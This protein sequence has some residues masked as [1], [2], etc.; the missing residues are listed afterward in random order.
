MPQI[1]DYQ[2]NYTINVTATEGVRQV[3]QFAAAVKELNS[4]KTT[5]STAI[6][7][8]N[9]MMQQIEKTFRPNGR[10]RDYTFKLDIET[11][12]TEEKLQRVKTL[13]TE[14]K[15]LTTSI[16][17]TVNAGQKL[18]TN[19][20]RSQTRALVNKKELEGQKEAAKK[21]ASD[22]MKSVGEVQKSITKVIGKINA[23][24][25]SLEKG[26][27]INIK[28]DVA[29][30]RLQ[31]ILSLL[32]QIKGASKMSLGIQMNS[33]G[34]T[35][36]AASAPSPAN[37]QPVP[38]IL[39]NNVWGQQ[40][41]RFNK[42]REARILK[43]SQA[44]Q[45]HEYRQNIQNKRNAFK[46]F[47]QEER[48]RQKIYDDYEKVKVENILR[49]ERKTEKQNKQNAAVAVRGIRQQV[50]TVKTADNSRR[51]AAINRLQYSRR[52]SLRNLPIVGVMN[53]YMAYS[54]I[55][56]ELS[57]AVNYSNIM[58]SAHSI[59]R[60]ADSDLSTFEARFDRMSRHIRKI[61]VDTK[62]TA[63]E[64][65]GAAKF[66]AMAGMDIATIN[67]SM[68]PIANLAL[69]GDNDVSLIA[70]LTTNIMSGYNIQSESMGS[71]ADIITSTISRANV[72]VWKK[73]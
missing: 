46:R 38:F 59:L 1:Q 55:K 7:N 71:V 11:K 12:G 28:T 23:A 67:A 65:A 66:L 60:V 6:T 30:R 64:I 72:N 70:D 19:A 34:K 3:Q 31:E 54:F 42:V 39:S 5:F 22:S 4:A 13:I 40:Q 18:D 9:G 56:S 43:E 68:R 17:L 25:L 2:V 51:R 36:P 69:I 62:F 35:F 49:R 32:H 41:A 15:E 44:E 63:V 52:P 57:S 48:R 45:E 47:E 14:I 61:G 27:E 58:E 33:P 21:T 53:A 24:L 50:V 37:V 26:R 29:Q 10:K 16:N 20:I 73:S 8:I